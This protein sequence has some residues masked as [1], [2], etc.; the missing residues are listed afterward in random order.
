MTMTIKLENGAMKLETKLHTYI[1]RAALRHPHAVPPLGW[2]LPGSSVSPRL[3]PAST[4][5]Q[6]RRAAPSISGNSI[7]RARLAKRRSQVAAIP[8]P[9]LL[10]GIHF[11]GCPYLKR[12]YPNHPCSP[13]HLLT[14]PLA[15]ASTIHAETKPQT[16]GYKARARLRNLRHTHTEPQ[17]LA[18]SLRCPRPVMFPSRQPRTYCFSSSHQHRDEPQRPPIFVPGQ[19]RS[20]GRAHVLPDFEEP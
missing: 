6:C 11:Q 12:Q 20:P 5:P 4:P 15:L 14:C 8:A 16:S 13:A 18:L 3:G 7:L 17:Q 19:A 10:A 9:E 1:G 2:P